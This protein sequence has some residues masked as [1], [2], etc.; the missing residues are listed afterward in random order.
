MPVAPGY[1]YGTYRY[2]VRFDGDEQSRPLRAALP[3]DPRRLADRGDHGLPGAAGHRR[4]RPA[5]WSGRP[6]STAGA[7][8][9]CPTP[10]SSC[11]A[12][13]SSAPAR[14]TTARCPTA[15]A[16]VDLAGSWI[17]PGLIDTHVHFSQTGWAD[18]RP[19]FIDVRERYPYERGD[20]RAPRAPRDLPPRLPLLGRHRGLRRRRLPLDLGAGRGG[21]ERHRGAARG[22]RRAAAVDPRLLAQPAGRAPVH[23]PGGRRGGA[24]RRRLSGGRRR[25]RGQGVVHP[26]R[27]PAVRRDGGGGRPRRA[28]RP[29]SAACRSSSTPPASRRPRRRCAPAPICWSTRSGTARWTTS[30]SSCCASA[31]R[32]TARP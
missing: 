8:R 30:S 23:P 17:T 19:D 16:E 22:R 32:S 10:S 15:S 28:R 3:G 25:R 13:A 12:A 26:P 1:V 4:R 6:W 2:R 24:R 9:L 21:R 5:P 11:A 29:A 31:A 7:A 27:R 20:R 18:G 14:A